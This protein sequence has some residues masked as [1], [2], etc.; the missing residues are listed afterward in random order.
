MQLSID[1]IRKLFFP[2]KKESNNM[3]RTCQSNSSFS[4]NGISHQENMEKSTWQANGKSEKSRRSEVVYN[5]RS[6]GRESNLRFSISNS[7]PPT[8]KKRKTF[9]SVVNKETSWIKVA[10]WG[11]SIFPFPSHVSIALPVFLAL[12]F[13][14]LAVINVDARTHDVAGTT[15]ECRPWERE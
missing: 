1:Y 7:P 12:D 8:T 14:Q 6:G 9:F 4:L 2:K 15:Y 5:A 3:A 10:W 11:T 13:W